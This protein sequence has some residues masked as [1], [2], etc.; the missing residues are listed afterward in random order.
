MTPAVFYAS[1]HHCCRLLMCQKKGSDTHKKATFTIIIVYNFDINK[2]SGRDGLSRRNKSHSSKCSLLR[3][4][5]GHLL[6]INFAASDVSPPCIHHHSGV[7]NI[8]KPTRVQEDE[9]KLKLKFF[10]CCCRLGVVRQ[11]SAHLHAGYSLLVSLDIRDS[12]LYWFVSTHLNN[13]V[14]QKSYI[15]KMKLLK[16]ISVWLEIWKLETK[17]CQ[18]LEPCPVNIGPLL[19]YHCKK[20]WIKTTHFWR[21]K[22]LQFWHH[23][24]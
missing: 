20:E 17:I 2:I 9:V 14:C 23:M 10:V 16:I 11:S 22:C 13:L 1:S 3:G 18:I 24:W 15:T 8:E 21:S 19:I 5:T 12:K 4:S 6:I 7:C